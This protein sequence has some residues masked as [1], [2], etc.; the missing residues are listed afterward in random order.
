MKPD[1]HRPS[2]EVLHHSGQYRLLESFHL[3]EMAQFIARQFANPN[4]EVSVPGW[5]KWAMLLVLGLGGGAFGYWL[6]A[7]LVQGN[8]GWQVLA[9][10]P[11]FLL[12]LLPLHE[13]IHALV[14]RA[15]GAG[16]VGFG[17]NPKSLMVY[18]YAQKYVLTLRENSLV[19]LMPFVVITALLVGAIGILP[20]YRLFLWGC[21]SLH[22]FACA[23]DLALILYARRNQGRAIFLYDDVEGEKR[24]YFF[25]KIA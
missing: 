5:R 4:P 6:G 20:G 24:S 21:L 22:S 9:V 25:E 7:G 19:A 8:S 18:A 23:G 15:L 13:A 16:R 3:D 14:F 11:T 17:W 12:I 2:V 10:L 1:D